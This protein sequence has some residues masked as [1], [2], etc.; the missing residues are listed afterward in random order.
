MKHIFT[1][2]VTCWAACLAGAALTASAET[3]K[4]DMK[5]G[6]W[7]SRITL[8]GPQAAQVKAEQLKSMPQ[9]MKQQMENMSP[10]ER[11]QMEDYMAKAGVTL[12]DDGISMKN[13]TVKLTSTT[14]TV[15]KCITQA[16]I[17]RGA[18]P[19]EK[20]GC[21]TEFKQADKNTFTVN[22]HCG[23]NGSTKTH[24]DVVFDSPKHYS[25]KGDMTHTINGSANKMEF[26]VD[27]TW[28]GSDCGSVE[29][30]DLEM[31]DSEM[32]DDSEIIEE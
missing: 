7:E 14:T 32:M 30:V 18:S 9:T 11:K 16:D 23:E 19:F 29:P 24:A 21:T 17:D 15:K 10:E 26:E 27:G 31:D 4:V 20:A 12:T 8:A 6:L 3:F 5:P 25:G 2:S 28:L 22:Q 1:V 13:G